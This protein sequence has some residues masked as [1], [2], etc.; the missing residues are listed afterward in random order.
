MANAS[1]LG[2]PNVHVPR[3]A[4]QVFFEGAALPG[5]AQNSKSFSLSY[6]PVSNQ[7]GGNRLTGA[8]HPQLTVPSNRK[9]IKTLVVRPTQTRDATTGYTGAVGQKVPFNNTN[10]RPLAGSHHGNVPIQAQHGA[11]TLRNQHMSRA[12]ARDLHGVNTT[13]RRGGSSITH[14]L[15]PLAGTHDTYALPATH[16]GGRNSAEIVTVKSVHHF[17]LH[18]VVVTKRQPVSPSR[19]VGRISKRTA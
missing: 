2:S 14:F 3:T 17:G 18:K 6:S 9:Q 10:V 19:P 12:T 16:A 7:V 5:H 8:W 1:I 4:E 11:N 13:S 15:K